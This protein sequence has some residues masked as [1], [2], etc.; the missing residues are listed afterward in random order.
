[1]G[2]NSP[3]NFVQSASLGPKLWEGGWGLWATGLLGAILQAF[4]P[5]L[6][7]L[8]VLR[9]RARGLRPW[10]VSFSPPQKKNLKKSML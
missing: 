10:R 8:C 2:A 5:V 7:L 6:L 9:R 4:E 3:T 1:V